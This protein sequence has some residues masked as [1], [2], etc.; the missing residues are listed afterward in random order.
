MTIK[1][2]IHKVKF[3]ICVT[4]LKCMRYETAWYVL[5]K[6]NWLRVAEKIT[7]EKKEKKKRS[8]REGSV[9]IYI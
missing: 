2:K 9:G 8:Q 1:L 7:E 6:N 5:G 4:S 3:L